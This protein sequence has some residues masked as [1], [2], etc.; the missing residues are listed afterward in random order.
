[1]LVC[2]RYLSKL[3]LSLRSGVVLGMIFDGE[4]PISIFNLIYCGILADLQHLVGIHFILNLLREVFPKEF[5]LFLEFDLVLLEELLEDFMRIIGFVL[6]FKV[7]I[8]WR[9]IVDFDFPCWHLDSSLEGEEWVMQIEEGSQEKSFHLAFD[10]I[11]YFNFG[12]NLSSLISQDNSRLFF[13]SHLNLQIT[14]YYAT[15]EF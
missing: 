3:G 10:Y 7:M 13:S 8:V 11:C 15:R 12:N 4:F 14:N 2:F 9:V 6:G 5:F 1:M